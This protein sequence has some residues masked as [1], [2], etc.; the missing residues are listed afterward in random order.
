M[1]PNHKIW[2]AEVRA[3]IFPSFRLKNQICHSVMEQCITRKKQHCHESVFD[4]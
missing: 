1:V 2:L 3:A 4:S